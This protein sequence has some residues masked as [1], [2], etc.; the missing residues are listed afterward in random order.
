MLGVGSKMAAIYGTGFNTYYMFDMITDIPN[1]YFVE[2]GIYRYASSPMYTLG[3]SSG[4]TALTRLK[5]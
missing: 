4:P 1:A 3:K 5:Y 2:V